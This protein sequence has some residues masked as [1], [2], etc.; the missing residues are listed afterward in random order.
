MNDLN[1]N[2]VLVTGSS[3]FIGRHLCEY[4][5]KQGINVI[6]LS[7]NG[8]CKKLV[9]TEQYALDL[10]DQI[11]VRELIQ[12]IKPRYVVHLAAVKERNV[13]A[14]EYRLVYD[15]NWQSSF[16]LIEA[17]QEVGTLRRFVFLG[18]TDEYGIQ[19]PPFVESAREAPTTSY[20]LSKLAVTQLLQTFAR[21]CD[22]P[23]VIL[24]PTLVYGPNQGL[25]M[26]LSAMIQSLV[27]G[28]RFAMTKGEQT[29]DYVYVDDLIAAIIAALTANYEVYG[30]LINISSGIPLRIKD[31]ALI[32]ARL[33]GDETGC[34][35]DF[36]ARDYRQGEAMEYWSTNN[37]AKALLNWRPFI[38]LEE[39]LRRT[40]QSFQHG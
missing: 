3:G 9:E 22:F 5:S 38:S 32:V 7:R 18:S 8:H 13:A 31:L 40:I 25:E 29:R 19:A 11:K 21:S 4:L 23:A 12:Y 17:C 1:N 37:L 34:L 6:A 39:G 14:S 27:C 28:K 15:G 20:G 10:R 35:L 36:G 2:S 24:R 30:Q 16:N 33:A 26:F